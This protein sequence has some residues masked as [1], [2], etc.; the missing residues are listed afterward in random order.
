M[1]KKGVEEMRKEIVTKDGKTIIRRSRWIRVRQA[2]NVT[3]R[4]SLAYYAMDENGYREGQSRYDPSNGTY[5]DYFVWNGRKWALEQFLRLDYP[6]FWEDEEG[7][8]QY[9][10]GYDGENYRDPILIELDECGEYVRV[11]EE[12]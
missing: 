3:P 10:S 5:L 1:L 11:Y 7:K 4:H 2:Y 8:L 9:L 12:G 6:V